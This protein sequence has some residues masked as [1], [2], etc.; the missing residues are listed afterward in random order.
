MIFFYVFSRHRT[1]FILLLLNYFL[2]FLI[3]VIVEFGV[4]EILDNWVHRHISHRLCI[5]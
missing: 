1:Q 2:A 3:K 4:S 5:A